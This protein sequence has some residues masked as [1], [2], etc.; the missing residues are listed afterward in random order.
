ML[1]GAGGVYHGLIHGLVLRFAFDGIRGLNVPLN[2]STK[3]HKV[4]TTD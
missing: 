1:E 2:V 3:P 4:D